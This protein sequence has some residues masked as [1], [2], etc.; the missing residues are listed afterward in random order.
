MNIG[1]EMLFLLLLAF[2]LFGPK[3]LP[4]I[5]RTIGRGLAE[6]KRASNELK[7][8]LENEMRQLEAEDREKKI[9]PPPPPPP[10]VAQP[11]PA[12][13]SSHP[14]PELRSR[15]LQELRA[16]LPTLDSPRGLIATLPADEFRG[17][18]TSDA[19][20]AQVRRVASILAGH[21]GLYVS[22]DGYAGEASKAAQS[23]ERAEAVRRLLIGS[24]LAAG[25]VSAQGKAD[26]RPVASNA[27]PRGRQQNSRVEI[28][29]TGDAI[30][31]LPLWD[32]PY[33]LTGSTQSP[34][35]SWQQ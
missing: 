25:T 16:V 15:L 7:G 4:E 29:I 32:H 24:G 28:V 21:P 26:S 12:R 34:S 31:R 22:V 19:S 27:T 3:K 6:F 13:H 30:G 18:A 17:A 10:A 35:R 1:P 5:G 2:L 9:S 14:A 23:E 20:S 33:P 11:Q 8:Q